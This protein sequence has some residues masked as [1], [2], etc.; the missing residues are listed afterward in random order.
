MSYL[1]KFKKNTVDKVFQTVNFICKTDVNIMN[2]TKLQFT[3]KIDQVKVIFDVE[4]KK[5]E[6]NAFFQWNNNN[7]SNQSVTSVN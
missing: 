4:R 7:S 5:T 2:H 1:Q 3:T 6:T